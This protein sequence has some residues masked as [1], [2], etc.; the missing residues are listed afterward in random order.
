MR[1][2]VV[3]FSGNVPICIYFGQVATVFNKFD[4]NQNDVWN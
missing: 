2:G 3:G 4:T 1:A